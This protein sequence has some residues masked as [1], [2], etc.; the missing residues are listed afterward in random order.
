MKSFKLIFESWKN[1]INSESQINS[2]ILSI[3]NKI[4]K[5]VE[6]ERIAKDKKDLKLQINVEKHH[7]DDSL[8]VVK[9]DQRSLVGITGSVTVKKASEKNQHI[10]SSD[11]EY[12][13]YIIQYSKAKKGFGPLLYEIIMEHVSSFS[14]N[15]ILVPDRDSVSLSA[16][17]VWEKFLQRNDVQKVILDITEFE[18]GEHR[19]ENIDKHEDLQDILYEPAE[20]SHITDYKTSDDIEQTSAIFDKGEEWEKSCLSKGYR[21]NNQSVINYINNSEYIEIVFD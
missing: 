16:Q 4:E 8:T 5:I 6:E 3:I 18:I 12:D 7:S 1:Y 20:L 17:S 19:K 2:N 14:S 11:F 15:A 13:A 9:F 10:I 21:K